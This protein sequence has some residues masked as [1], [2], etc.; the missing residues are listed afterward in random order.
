MI[1]TAFHQLRFILSIAFGW[2]FSPGSL[3]KFV[4]AIRATLDEFGVIGKDGAELIA[5]VPLDAETQREVQT[6]RFRAAAKAAAETPYYAGLFADQKIDPAKLTLEDRSRVPL[7]P[8][9][10]VRDHPDSFVRRGAKPYIRATT[11]GTTGTPTSIYF[12]QREM[13]VY[14]ALS[15]LGMMMNGTLTETDIIQMSVS[16]RGALG[17]VTLAGGAGH[18]GAMVY[19]TGVIAPEVALQLLREERQIPGKKSKTSH[20]YT[21]PSYLGM[22]VEV[23]LAAGLTPADFGLKFISI[24]GEVVTEGLKRRARALF[25]DVK[26][27]TGYGI[28]EL[29]GMGSTM[30]PDGNLSFEI[31]QGL[32]EIINPD[33]GQPAAPGQIG[34]IVGTP[35]PPYRETSLLLRYD[36]EDL[37]QALEQTAGTQR[38]GPVL[39][40]KRLAV[41]HADGS[42]TTPRDVMEALEALDCVPLPARFTFYGEDDGVRVEV[43]TRTQTEA[44]REM[45]E[46]SL[47]QHGVRVSTVVLCAAQADFTRPAYPLRGDLREITFEPGKQPEVVSL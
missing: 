33:S 5:G 44:V 4:A 15:A 13:R 19:Q 36:T 31:S 2:S 40:K 29:W 45:V 43:I 20:L 37:V 21:Y 28:T 14:F 7:T 17:N 34:T 16:A 8:K 35:F 30:T 22:L 12:S 39:G 46:A 47:Q 3:E 23:G 9:A 32:L 25:G 24:G 42:W 27:E 6:R 18:V 10:D 26:Y 38:C 41:R 1:S 11:T